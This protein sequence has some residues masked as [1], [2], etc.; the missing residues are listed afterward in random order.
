MQGSRFVPGGRAV[1]TPW[2]RYL[3]IRLLHAPLISLAA[4]HRYTDTTN[5]FRAYSARFLSDPRVAPF[6]DVFS[7]YELHY[8][9]AIRAARLGFRVAELPVTRTYPSHGPHRRRFTACAA[10]CS[11]CGRSSRPVWAD[12]IR[13][14][15]HRHGG[16]T[17][18]PRALI[19]ITG[20]VG[21]NLQQQ[22]AFDAGF[23]SR[24]I[25]TMA[26]GDYSLVVCA[27]APAEKWRANQAPEADQASL[28]RL[29]AAL[30]QVQADRVVLV[31]TVDVYPSPVAV[32]EA[33]PIDP[34]SGQPYG[35]HRLALERFVQQR[36]QTT[37]LRLPGLYGPGIKKNVIFDV[38]HGRPIDGLAPD[39]THRYL[40]PGPARARR[41]DGARAE[42]RPRESRHRAGHRA[43]HRR[44]GLRPRPGGRPDRPIVHYDMRTRHAASFG[45]RGDYLETRDAVL[46]GIRAF[47]E[48][49]GWRRP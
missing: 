45:G 24:N 44:P 43:R 14:K 1:R 17:V 4:G 38:L 30:E 31:S 39:S 21:G 18:K 25:D 46:S 2:A 42:P 35:R 37:V 27:G 19:G 12:S 9:L 15:A 36:F 41:G 16:P 47:A 13:L 11:C 3:G 10:T 48:S 32:D 28:A 22:M 29:T 23:H 49:Q 8:Y 5:G 6:R 40:R 26:G 20:F 33:T 7:A 34:A